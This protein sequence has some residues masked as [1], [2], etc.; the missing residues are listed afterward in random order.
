M[1]KKV[2]KILLLTN[3]DSDNCGDQV[4]EAC[5]LSL[6]KA[7]MKNL[8]IDNYKINSRAASIVSQKY[9]ET[10]NPELLK[11]AHSVIA[12][13]DIV[14]FGGAPL[15][16]YDHQI[17]YERTAVTLEIAE[18]YHT[19]VIFS[20]IGIETYDEENEKC[21]RLKKTLNFDCVKQI[22]TRDH[23]ELLEKFKAREDLLIGKVSDPAVLASKIFDGLKEPQ[24]K[25][26]KKKVGIFVLRAYGFTDNGIALPKAEAAALW[27]GVIKELEERGYDYELLTSGHFGDEAFLDNLIREYGVDE[28]KCAFNINSPEIL[29]NKIASFDAVVTCRL[30]PS[31]ISFALKVPAIGLIWNSKVTGFYDSIGYSD[32]AISTEGLTPQVLANKLEEVMEQ[33]VVQD[34]KYL[35]TV[36]ET[37]FFGIKKCLNIEDDTLV[38]YTYEELMEKMPE[39]PGTTPEEQQ[40]KI[41][42]KFRRAYRNYNSLQ[43]KN[44]ANKKIIKKL[45]KKIKELE[46]K[47]PLLYKIAKKGKNIIKKFID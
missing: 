10:K 19:P 13:S 39:F 36:Y 23:I 41:K 7:V 43:D 46:E 27:K 16:N 11:T 25:K 18:Q 28:K 45:R 17:F 37:L 38:P 3:R 5:D 24:V 12:D 47:H 4:I 14:V 29:V 15:F 42:R 8:K 44:A 9:V 22:T 6:L 1:D 20:A 2:Y 33:G 26:N 34:T 31:I 40:E 21:Q 30:H 32:R 35:N